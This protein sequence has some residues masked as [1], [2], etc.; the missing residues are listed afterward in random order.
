M[1]MGKSEGK[2]RA[3]FRRGKQASFVNQIPYCTQ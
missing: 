3:G 2:S 1:E